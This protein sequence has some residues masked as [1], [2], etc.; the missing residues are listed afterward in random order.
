MTLFNI[1]P[2]LASEA[3]G[4]GVAEKDLPERI[5]PL[6]KWKSCQESLPASAFSSIALLLY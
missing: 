1:S 6:Q 3:Y 2:T 4:Y 5:F